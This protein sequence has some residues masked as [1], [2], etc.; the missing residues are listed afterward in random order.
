MSRRAR[1]A[2]GRARGVAV[3]ESFGSACAQ[4]AEVSLV[5]GQ[6]RVHRVVAAFDCATE[7]SQV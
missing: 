6:P 7:R 3:V 2:A 1:T 4:V 5:D